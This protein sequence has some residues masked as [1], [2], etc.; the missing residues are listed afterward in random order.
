[1]TTIAN[2]LFGNIIIN[3]NIQ[4]VYLMGLI[5]SIFHFTSVQLDQSL[6]EL[7]HFSSP[8][9]THTHTHTHTTHTHTPGTCMNKILKRSGSR[10]YLLYSFHEE[11]PSVDERHQMRFRRLAT[12]MIKNGCHNNKMKLTMPNASLDNALCAHSPWIQWTSPPKEAKLPARLSYQQYLHSAVVSA[13]SMTQSDQ[14][15]AYL[16]VGCGG[17]SGTSCN[18]N[19]STECSGSFWRCIPS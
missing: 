1:M 4:L 7:A 9:H 15:Q 6:T 13:E 8:A 5:H 3:T 16:R 14:K 19:V 11:N 2:N 10:F 17:K 18:I 12:Y